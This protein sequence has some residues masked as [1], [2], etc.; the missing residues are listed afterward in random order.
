M[1][2]SPQLCQQKMLSNLLILAHQREIAVFLLCSSNYECEYFSCL[3]AIFIALCV[4]ELSVYECKSQQQKWLSDFRSDSWDGPAFSGLNSRCRDL[5]LA[6]FLRTVHT[7]S[8]LGRENPFPPRA[9]LSLDPTV[10]LVP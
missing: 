8:T 9:C 10:W 6:C 7:P 4:C 5:G 1:F 3:K 2:I